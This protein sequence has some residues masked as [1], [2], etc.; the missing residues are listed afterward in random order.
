[1]CWHHYSP[2][3]TVYYPPSQ[4]NSINAGMLQFGSHT[5][6]GIAHAGYQSRIE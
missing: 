3:V 4:A 6:L 5:D 2:H 1:M